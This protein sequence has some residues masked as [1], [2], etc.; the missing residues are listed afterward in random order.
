MSSQIYTQSMPLVASPV[1]INS[2]CLGPLMASSAGNTT[3]ITGVPAIG[4]ALALSILVVRY[5]LVVAGPV[6]IQWLSS[7]G[8]VLSGPITFAAAGEGVQDGEG[9]R[10][11]DPWSLEQG[12]ILLAPP[13]LDLVMNLSANVICGGYCKFRFI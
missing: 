12:G 3:M 13:G 11:L 6:T 9:Y 7:K 1:Y 2:N 8:D 10:D 5:T 4:D